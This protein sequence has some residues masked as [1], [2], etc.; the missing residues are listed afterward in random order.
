MKINEFRFL[1][2]I[3]KFINTTYKNWSRCYE[4]GYV[5]D[6][7]ARNKFTTVHNACCGSNELHKL[8]ADDLGW[9]VPLVLNSDMNKP[10]VLFDNFYQ[11]N[12][13]EP[14][15][16]KFDI[17]VCI[18]TIEEL[19]QQ[20]REKVLKNL[21]FQV[22]EGGRLIITCDYPFVDLPTLEKFVGR[23]I[24][25]VPARLDGANSILPNTEYR[26]WNIIL[27][28]IENV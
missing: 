15:Y 25:Q 12:I 7:A 3:E 13:L 8:F 23:E 24:R 26:D 27:I 10:L 16:E 5:L 19:P 2:P 11:V 18:S 1:E 4:W 6:V 17:V 21:L 22:K 28:D 9:F 14:F 20:E